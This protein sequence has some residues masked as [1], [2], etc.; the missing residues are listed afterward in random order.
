[1]CPPKFQGRLDLEIRVDRTEGTE[2]LMAKWV[3]IYDGVVWVQAVIVRTEGKYSKL[4]PTL[5]RRLCKGLHAV[6]VIIREIEQEK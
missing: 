6:I 2:I 4:P 1:M 5:L 3:E